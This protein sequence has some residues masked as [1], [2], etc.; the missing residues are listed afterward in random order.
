MQIA[1]AAA[2]CSRLHI[3]PAAAGCNSVHVVTVGVLSVGAC[4]TAMHMLHLCARCN[5]R[6]TVSRCMLHSY[7]HAATLC[8]GF[9]PAGVK[10]ATVFLCIYFVP[11]AAGGNTVHMLQRSVHML[12][13]VCARS[14]NSLHVLHYLYMSYLQLQVATLSTCC[15]L[16]AWCTCSCRL[17]LCAHAPLGALTAAPGGN[18]KHAATSVHG[19]TATAG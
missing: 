8:A 2:G 5:C 4:C 15:N 3:L 12:N 7:A 14:C 10:V 16:C 17:Q 1:T 11:V 9:V 18:R 13:S 19:V 6:C